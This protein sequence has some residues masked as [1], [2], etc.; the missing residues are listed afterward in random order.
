LKGEWKNSTF[1]TD[2]TID[3][4]FIKNNDLGF[5]PGSAQ[6]AFKGL[7]FRMD[8]HWNANI[9][10]EDFDIAYRANDHEHRV[11]IRDFN[12]EMKTQMDGVKVIEYKA[13]FYEGL[14]RGNLYIDSTQIPS[15]ITSQI[16]LEDVNTDALEELLIQFAQFDGRMSST[17]NF[18]NIPQFELSGNITMVD[19]R[20]TDF[21]FFNW[22]SDTF[23]L[24][25]LRAIDFGRA[26]TQFLINKKHV[27][28]MGIHLKTDDV[29]IRG[30]YDINNQN[31][32]S[33]KLTVALSQ[34]LLRQSPKFKPVLTIFEGN[35]D[36]L[37][38]E[39]QLS[40]Y[41]GA[42]NFQ[43]MPSDVKRKIQERI[44]DFVERLIEKNIDE[45]MEPVP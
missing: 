11:L 41:T 1:D 14:L 28:L 12:A 8:R 6:A 45:M 39:F 35:K 10:W 16:T 38:F 44:P 26:S 29:R 37:N 43:W 42:V 23:R 34:G 4:D 30:Y 33:S 25:S 21:D 13:P 7:R 19:G 15:K 3:I 40:G 5:L 32:V 27:Q 24:P 31:L 18:T 22:V 17:M 2:G 9:S 36:F 20:M